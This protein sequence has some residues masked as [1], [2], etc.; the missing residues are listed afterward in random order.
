MIER[1]KHRKDGFSQLSFQLSLFFILIQVFLSFFLLSYADAV[2]GVIEPRGVV[3]PE[4]AVADG[5]AVGAVVEP[6]RK[7]EKRSR[8][9][10]R[11]RKNFNCA[12]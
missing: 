10:K 12:A 9:K 7:K 4:G 2:R 3:E 6:K 1:R 5:V 8:K 11:L